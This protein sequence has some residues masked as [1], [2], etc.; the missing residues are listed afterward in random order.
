MIEYLILDDIHSEI[1]KKLNQ[2]RHNYMIQIYAIRQ[3]ESGPHKTYVALGRMR[4]QEQIPPEY[5][6]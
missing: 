6:V 3:S 4:N 5:R 2:W 1:Q